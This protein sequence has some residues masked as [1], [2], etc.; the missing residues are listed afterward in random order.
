M[1]FLLINKP[2]GITSHD[3]VDRV[4]R[5]TNERT[6]GHAGTLDPFAT[7]LLIIGVGREST[8]HLSL[9]LNMG[10]TYNATI[11][12]GKDSTTF[13]PEGEITDVSIVDG[14]SMA[15]DS[16]S[17]E[18]AMKSLTGNL[19]QIP[20]MHSAIKIG[21]KK[22]YELARKGIEIDRPARSVIV[23]RFDL[24]EEESTRKE[25]R[26]LPF[27]LHAVIDCSSG[28]YI[29][30]LA[31]DLGAVLGTKAYLTALERS[32]IGPYSLSEATSLSD[33]H[34]ENWQQL[35]KNLTP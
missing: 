27:E 25:P 8:K 21:G 26:T 3:V 31:R 15:V 6:V 34:A 28:T 24:V 35:A 9:F 2:A 16:K 33:L 13:D 4:R 20:P 5:I 29:R 17:I 22:L 30:A 12:I 32:A 18:A 7:G 11:L 10:K 23:S 1:P 19:E 14:E